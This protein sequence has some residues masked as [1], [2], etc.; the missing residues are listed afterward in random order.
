MDPKL[1]ISPDIPPGP[2]LIAESGKV[3]EATQ[4]TLRG[5]SPAADQDGSSVA[6]SSSTQGTMLHNLNGDS[7]YTYLIDSA[8]EVWCWSSKTHTAQRLHGW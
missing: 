6:L 7:S 5:K 2:A 8:G 3:V 4:Q 1:L